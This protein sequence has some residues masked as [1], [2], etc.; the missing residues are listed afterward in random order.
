MN[1]AAKDIKKFVYGSNTR[2]LIPV[3]QRVPNKSDFEW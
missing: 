2:L 3:G 1:W